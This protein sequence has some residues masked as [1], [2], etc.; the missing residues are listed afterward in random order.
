MKLGLEVIKELPHLLHMTFLAK[1]ND[2]IFRLWA[3][4][5]PEFLTIGSDD[6]AMKYGATID[7]FCTV[8]GIVDAR[9]GEPPSILDTGNQLI[10]HAMRALAN[11]RDVLGRPRDH[12]GLT[13]I[14]IY[15]PMIGIAETEAAHAVRERTD[16]PK[17]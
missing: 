5:K 15:N 12:W 8:V 11:F 9:I 16:P 6:L 2:T 4:M 17:A 1:E 10:D 13:P 7:V 14:A 3:A